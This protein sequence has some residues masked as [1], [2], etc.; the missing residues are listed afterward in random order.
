VSDDARVI[1]T[2]DGSPS[3][4]L[5]CDEYLLIMAQSFW[6]HR[7]NEDCVFELAVRDLPPHRAYLVAAG[8]QTAVEYLNGLRFDQGMLAWLDSLGAYDRGFLDFLA[9]LRFGGD[10]DAVPEGTVTGAA[11]PLL[12]VRAPRIEATLLESALLAIVDHETMVASK[13]ARIVEAASGRQV[14]DFS[15][16]RLHGVGSGPGVAR[17][18]YIA[19]AAGTATVVAGRRYGIPLTGTM[20]HQYLL[21][22]GPD[23][24]QEA[25]ERFLGDYPQR[26]ILLVDTYDTRRGVERAI[27]ASRS[28]GISLGAIRLDSGDLDGLSREARALLDAAGMDETRIIVSGDLDEWRIQLLVRAG[29]PVDSFG[30]GTMLGTSADA[31]HLNGIYKLVAVSGPEGL[32]PVMKWSAA[33]VTDPGAHQVFRTAEGD[34][35]GLLAEA[36]EGRPLLEPVMRGGLLVAALPGLDAVRERCRAERE[37]LPAEVRRLD[38]FAVWPVRR[39]PSLLRLRR[40]LSGDHRAVQGGEPVSQ[41]KSVS[42]GAALIA[43]DVQADFLPGGALAVRGGDAVISELV[44][45]AGEVDVVV[46]SRDFH[47][48]GHSSFTDQGGPWPVHCVAG[49]PGAALHPQVDAIADLVVSKG[50]D[51]GADAYSAFDGT[52]LA[53]LLRSRGVT[54]VVVGGLAT[55]YCVCATAL[56]SLGAGFETEVVEA[57]VRAVDFAA[58]DGDR[59]LEEMRR[60]GVRVISHVP[61]GGRR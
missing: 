18:A 21:G 50:R 23:G 13:T 37:A 9:G 40:T 58:G 44:A 7:Q 42:G 24:E 49:T 59:A 8:L 19:G 28:T 46:A 10:L 20:A 11:V 41:R 45:L 3:L 16:R 48:P 34:T 36:L 4:A 29:A 22:F 17:A 1:P 38:D 32:V 31:P 43:V 2:A 56:D 33:K 30:V 25:F 14:W 39:S 57:A 26:A 35:V 5:Y 54:R 12:R 27:A 51:P 60:A 6:R 53:G 52:D 15:L 47:P 61:A 55:D